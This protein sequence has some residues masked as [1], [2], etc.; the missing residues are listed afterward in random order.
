MARN[1]S[2]NPVFQDE[3]FWLKIGVDYPEA[4][5]EA[6]ENSSLL[7]EELLSRFLR[8][9]RKVVTNTYD[10]VKNFKN[11]VKTRD[12]AEELLFS[13]YVESLWMKNWSEGVEFEH[14]DGSVDELVEKLDEDTDYEDVNETFGIIWPTTPQIR[15][16]KEDGEVIG[17]RSDETEPIVVKKAEESIQV[18]AS[19]ATLKSTAR[20]LRNTE[21]I[22]EV[23]PES[24]AVEISPNIQA[25]LSDGES[26][27]EVIGVKFNESEL[28][29]RSRIRVKNERSVVNDLGVLSEENVISTAGVSSIQ[30][31]YLRDMRFGGK[32]RVKVNHADQGFRFEL[33]A[34]EKLQ[35]ERE[36]FKTRFKQETGVDFGVEY[37]Y[38]AQNQRH[39]FNRVLSGDGGAYDRYFEEL[40]EKVRRYA[41]QFTDVTYQTQKICFECREAVGVSLDVCSECGASNFSESFEQVDVSINEGRVAYHVNSVLGEVE[42][43]LSDFDV[44]R[45]GV[46]RREMNGRPVVCSDFTSTAFEQRGSPRSTRHEVFFVPQGNERQPRQINNYLLKCVFLTYGESAV[47]DYEGFGRVSLHELLSAEHPEK[48][49]GKAIHDAVVGV[50]SRTFKKANE[51]F[52]DAEEYLRLVSERGFGGDTSALEEYY[53]PNQPDKFEKH[54]FYLMKGLF[55]QTERWGRHSKREADALLVVPRPGSR[56]AYAAKVDPKLSHAADGYPLGTSGEDQVSRYMTNDNSVNA[57]RSKTGRE[58]PDSLVLV[59][60]NFNSD[61]LALRARGVQERLGDGVGEY[62]PDLV[63]MEYEALVELYQLELDFHRALDNPDVKRRF[64]ELVIEELENVSL[65]E[66]A[67]FVHFDG[68]SVSA[69]RDGLLAEAKAHDLDPVRTYSQ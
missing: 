67:R 36:R 53:K 29:E 69:V 20:D 54:V 57:L 44:S 16:K 12:D 7:P 58:Q 17:V 31:I 68:G 22:E 64:R 21:D 63:F 9:K 35:R 47:D 61:R 39:L 26:D 28:P 38:G 50:R 34:P 66:G 59:S 5:E 10:S 49:V 24:E 55:V 25:F 30:K 40:D 42:P 43:V 45:W 11:Q 1:S 13:M 33:I 18:R 3:E 19:T 15:R 6:T 48:V 51:A 41:E 14:V 46:E 62:E 65:R 60:Q 8:G 23:E 27:F 52:D 32:Y 2:D 37:E 4:I 56:K